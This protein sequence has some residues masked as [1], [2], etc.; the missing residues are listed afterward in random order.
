VFSSHRRQLVAVPPLAPPRRPVP[1]RR[2]PA[3]P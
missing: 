3:H 1:N 2:V